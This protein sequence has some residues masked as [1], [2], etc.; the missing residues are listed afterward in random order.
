[1]FIRE[2][3]YPHDG[4][5]SSSPLATRH[6]TLA[7]PKADVP[8]EAIAGVGGRAA[9]RVGSFCLWFADQRWEWSDEVYR[10]HGY[11]P[12]SVVPTTRLVLSHKHPDDGEAVQDLLDRALHSGG[13]F[14]SRHRICDTAGDEHSVIVVA[15][16][17]L[18]ETGVVVGTRGYYVDVTEAL[19]E[20]RQDVFDETL[21]KV[22]EARAEIEQAKGALR[23][24]YGIN[25]EQAFELLRWRSQ[26]NNVKL[27]ALA[28][29]LVSELG[30]LAS[31]SAALRTEFDHLILT[32]HERIPTDHGRADGATG[33]IGR[34]PPEQ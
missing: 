7:A 19:Q 9:S 28:A 3:G 32:L 6:H 21:P 23:V 25:D 34:R 1:M 2:H 26:K 17:M 31:V 24:V 4:E 29:Q 8:A 15:D 16:R 27:R 13:S 20:S 30:T 11:E 22:V 12:G 18:G 5:A 10:M 33:W 14:F